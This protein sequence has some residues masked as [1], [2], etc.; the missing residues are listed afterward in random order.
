MLPEDGAGDAK[1]GA[2]HREDRE[3]DPEVDPEA[4]QGAD[5]R[6]GRKLRLKCN[7]GLSKPALRRY[8]DFLCGNA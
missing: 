2:D 3:G 8:P 1:E 4:G 7:P 6:E 5:L